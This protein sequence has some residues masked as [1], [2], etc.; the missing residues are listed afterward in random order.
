MVFLFL[1]VLLSLEVYF[2]KKILHSSS[3]KRTESHIVST[4]RS[5]DILITK[6]PINVAK[7]GIK[8]SKKDIVKNFG[9]FGLFRGNFLQGTA[10]TVSQKR[11]L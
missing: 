11:T 10:D 5:M 4:L 7:I 6:Y 9:C 3:K 1:A 2:L 8:L